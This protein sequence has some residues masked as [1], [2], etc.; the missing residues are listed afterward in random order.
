MNALPSYC[1]LDCLLLYYMSS[2]GNATDCKQVTS[3]RIIWP[4]SLLNAGGLNSF[5]NVPFSLT[6]RIES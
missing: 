1:K 6:L 3:E 5:L 2:P 4:Y